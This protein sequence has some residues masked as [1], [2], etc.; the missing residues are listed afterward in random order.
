[1]TSNSPWVFLA[2]FTLFQ[3]MLTP[4]NVVYVASM[5]LLTPNE[6]RGA[7]V[8]FFSATMG[9]VAISLGAI[10]I[11]AISDY[12]YGGNAIGLGMATVYAFSLPLASL[13]LFRG[14][15]AMREAV[16]AAEAWA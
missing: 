13:A 12:V 2:G 10:L 11:A 16:K 4:L 6:L 9:L 14:C 7:G 8:A 5:N 1:M 3:I 15:S